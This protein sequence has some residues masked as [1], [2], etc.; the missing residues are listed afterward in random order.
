M[1]NKVILIGRLGKDVEFRTV[2]GGTGLAKFSLATD[3]TR[4]NENGEKTTTTEWHR[5]IVWRRLAEVARDYL[6]KGSLIQ[7]EGKIH[8]DSYENKEG[9]KIYTTDIVC[10]NFT[11]L[12]G[13]NDQGSGGGGG[14][15]NRDS[16][17]N[18]KSA[19]Q[20]KPA[21]QA[22]SGDNFNDGGD[23]LPF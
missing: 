12:G 17:S 8:Y 14:N 10:D 3:E 7:L 1:F 21:A 22:D 9:R 11:M 6:K 16:Q 13:R 20:S 23:D 2:A 15:W 18:Q 4:R 5:V 19:P